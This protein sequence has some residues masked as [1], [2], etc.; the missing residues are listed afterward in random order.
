M[1]RRGISGGMLSVVSLL[2]EQDRKALVENSMVKTSSSIKQAAKIG[3]QSLYA[4]ADE[5]L[6]KYKDFDIIKEMKARKGANLLWVRARAIDADVVNTN[7]DYFSEEE[8][9]KE[10]DYQGKK[11]PAY[12]TFEGVPIYTNHKNDNIEEAK[13][14]VVYAEW[15]DEEKC[16][17]CVFFIDE[18]AY[19]DIARGIRQAYIRDVSMGCFDGNTKIPTS[20]GF[21]K[22]IDVNENDKL[23][24]KNGNLVNIVNRQEYDHFEKIHLVTLE[25]GH[26]I[27]CTDY[28]PFLSFTQEQWKNRKSLKRP[29]DTNG[30]KLSKWVQN[31]ISPEYT[32]LENLKPGDVFLSPIGGAVINDADF[33]INRAK[34]VGYFLAEG[35]YDSGSHLN[36]IHF[37]F[38]F[39]EKD[40]YAQEVVDLIREEFNLEAKI[41]VPKAKNVC[42]VSI[43][44]ENLKNWFFYN[45]GRWSSKKKLNPKW[46][47]APY[48]IQKTVIGSWIDGD[49]TSTID[50]RNNNAYLRVTTV[51]IDL[52]DQMSFML[53][54]LG[55]YHSCYFSYKGKKFDYINLESFE[56]FHPQCIIQIPSYATCE[57]KGFLHKHVCASSLNKDKHTYNNFLA[58]KIISIQEIPIK[59]QKVYTFQ[60]ESGNYLAHNFI[61]KNCSVDL[62][63]CSICGNEATTEKDYCDCLKKYKGKMHP[64]GK[65]AFE[66]NYGIKFIEL[67]CVGDGAFESCEILELYDQDELLQKAQDTI[68]TA[69]SLNS[70]ITLAASINE[71]INDK[72]DVEQALRQL[73]NLNQSIIKI[74]QTA[75][76]LVGG[77]LLGGAGSQNATV[78]KILQGLGIDPSSSLNILDLVNLALNFLEVAVLN[79]FSRKDNID[80]THV[81]K[82]TKAMGELQNTLQDMI[83]DGIETSGQKNT[84]PMIPPQAP[85]QPPQTPQPPQTQSVAPTMNASL[86]QPMV[87][88]MVAPFSQTPYAMPL[89]GGVSA[90]GNNLRFV[91]ASTHES[92]EIETKEIKLNK[93]GRLAVAL[94]NLREACLI[95]KKNDYEVINNLPQKNKTSASS[96]DKNIM[97]QFKK[98]AQDYKKQ[99]SVALAIDIKLDD[100]SGNRV[101]LSTDKGIKGYH[102]GALTN[103]SPSL[104]DS[105]LAQMENGDGYRVAADLLTDFSKVVKTAMQ[106]DKVDVLMVF[107]ENLEQDKDQ[108]FARAATDLE[109]QHRGDKNLQYE[110]KLKSH[111]KNDD[112]LSTLDEKLSAKRTS[113]LVRIV[114]ELSADAKKGLGREPLEEMLHPNF[115]K[116]TVPGREIMSNVVK[117]IARACQAA[118][119]NPE[120]VVEFLTK[121]SSNEMGRLLKIARLGTSTRKYNNIMGKYAQTDLQMQEE[122]SKMPMAPG[123]GTSMN[124]MPAPDMETEAIKGVADTATE[125][126]SEGDIMKALEV[127]KDNFEQAVEK[128]NEIL[129]KNPEDDKSDEMKD[130]L[131]SDDVDQ[132]AMKGAVTGLSLSGEETGA[133]PSDLVDSVNS[134]PIGDMASG[135][136]EAR[137][138]ASATARAKQKYTKTASK[139]DLNSNIVGWLA[140]MANHHNVS[141]EKMALAAKLFC[142]YDNAA[143][144]VLAK[145]IRTSDV[146]VIDETTHA[147]TI[148]CTLDDIGTDVKDAAF[149]QKFRDFAVDLLSRSGYEVDPSTFALTE[150]IVSEDGTVQGKVSTKA[151]KYFSPEMAMVSDSG[152]DYVDEDK[153]EKAVMPEGAMVGEVMSESPVA[154]N[155]ESMSQMIMSASAKTAKRLARMQNIMRLA[156]LGFPGGSA[157]PAP[158]PG[159]GAAPTDPTGGLGAGMAG[160]AADLGLGSLT[161]SS[162]PMPSDT[163]INDSPEP[164]NKA[165]WGTIC[166]Q[167]GSKDVDIANGEGSCNSCNAQLKYKFTVE[168]APPDEKSQGAGLEPTEPM[169]A[170]MP[171]VGGPTGAP[172]AGLAGV[173]GAA[174]GGA[175]MALASNYKVMTKIAYKTSAD[176]YAAAL[177]DNFNKTAA[178]RLPVGMICPACGSRTASKQSKNTYCYDCGTIAVSDIQRLKDEPGMLEANI[179][180]I[181]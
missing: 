167:C 111:R 80:L 65:K 101:V 180:W 100:K 123:E 28:H 96:G 82:L 18:D 11:M 41:Y 76:T 165:P 97:D 130:A 152:L 84:Q 98:I 45:C 108:E 127:I 1:V 112:H 69:Q 169:S 138:P 114:S 129:G 104:T 92:E 55:I 118:N 74:A 145:A 143:R 177:S 88:T 2:K 157:A 72:R 32:R 44:N 77:Q 155:P 39:S 12:K 63:R 178:S 13:G 66:Y 78:V 133:S 179:F 113:N 43:S 176:V 93:I 115:A 59:Q 140:D 34:L 64:S 30:K 29:K 62:G 47:Q 6:D 46:L 126:T 153:L 57:L 132:D 137:T 60:T 159:A 75:G 139:K 168:V 67:S 22:I 142:S 52:F 119:S 125:E 71:N 151:T 15:D 109:G 33:N 128:L 35:S 87:G 91:W 4:N 116:S 124:D 86:E 141:S 102:Q 23:F 154:A 56:D 53:S 106:E 120:E 24:D 73:Q 40:S 122:T 175:P 164:G 3:L 61:S 58:R 149:N 181:N 107:N 48:D 160:G 90:S 136:A 146:Q 94:D 10:M 9:T 158:A 134:T 51:S 81:A 17:Y 99:N 21:K 5:V 25:G 110:E 103:W 79:L 173:P 161:G 174:P 156:Q 144:T 31:D 83:D 68:K 49:G 135:I 42:R 105:Q 89:G 166:P 50:K 95:P 150:I 8:L 121:L 7:G 85:A 14:M 162:E 170:P 37:T 147:T 26:Q 38:N 148:T 54:R 36:R 20:N 19:P 172:E 70:S 171:P 117:G 27:K 163:P 131:V 16:V